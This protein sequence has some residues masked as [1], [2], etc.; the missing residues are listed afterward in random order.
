MVALVMPD[1]ESIAVSWAKATADLTALLGTKIA[2]RLPA[3]VD[4]PFLRAI[5]VGGGPEDLE[6]DIDGALIQWDAYAARSGANGETPDYRTA[7]LIARTLVAAA[8]ASANMPIVPASGDAAWV[9]GFTVTSGP[10][11]MDE[12]TNWARFRVDTLM[13]TRRL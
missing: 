4:L 1:A 2:T 12:P 8:R 6:A 5:R 9:Y 11:R 7:S 3:K 10:I 13:W